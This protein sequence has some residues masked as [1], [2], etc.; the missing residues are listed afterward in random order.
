MYWKNIFSSY[1]A[2]YSEIHKW[3]SQEIVFYVYNIH[4]HLSTFVMP[5]S[6]VSLHMINFKLSF[7]YCILYGANGKVA[8]A[9]FGARIYQQYTVVPA[10]QQYTVV[11]AYQQ[12]TVIPAYQQYTVIPAY[13]QYTVVPAYQQYTVIPAYQ[14]YTVIPANKDHSFW[15]YKTGLLQWENCHLGYLRVGLWARWFLVGVVLY[16][17]GHHFY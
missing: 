10:Y 16:K 1:A 6:C 9:T 4:P 2:M 7:P 15:S 11:P 8:Q 17:A 12:Y 3:I 13:Q 5:D 14:Q